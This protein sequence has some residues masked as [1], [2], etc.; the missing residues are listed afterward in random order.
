MGIFDKTIERKEFDAFKSEIYKKLDG[1]KSDIDLKVTDSEEIA[2]AAAENATG[3]LSRIKAVEPQVVSAVETLEIYKNNALSELHKMQAERESLSNENS[4]ILASTENSKKLYSEIVEARNSISEI[5]RELSEN[6]DKMKAVLLEA[7][8]LPKSVEETKELVLG[9]K[10]L[11]ENIQ[12][13]LTHSM[14]RKADIDDIHKRVFGHEIKD[15]EGNVERVDGLKDKLDASYSDIEA[16]AEGLEDAISSLVE[17]IANKH[18]GFL[19]KKSK[20]FDLLVSNSNARIN[21]VNDQLKA[22]LPGGLAAGLSAAYEG[23]KDEEVISLKRFEGMFFWAIVGLVIVSVIPLAV[24]IYL[25]KWKQ[26]E[27]MKVIQETPSLIIA[28]LPLYFP[29]LWLAYSMNKKVNLS[30][31]LIEEYTHKAVLGKTFS[32]LSNQIDTLPH[33]SVVK[34]DLRTRLLFNIL[35]V[36]AENPGKL[37]TDYNKSDHPIMEV[38]ESSKRLSESVEYLSKIPGLSSLAKKLS[39]KNSELLMLH[40]KKVEAGF[41]AQDVIDSKEVS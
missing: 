5:V 20:D 37:I 7:Q 31:R 28:M 8:Q 40:G 17:D 26:M 16:R 11:N 39:D 9:A 30:K 2:R 34:E 32:G 13:L 38:L 18:E 27:L 35:Q 1:L 10:S 22:L 6:S 36:S 15:D 23:K 3:L 29:I 41:A 12:N 25:L 19:D 24:D 14:K 33:E 21:E 4:S